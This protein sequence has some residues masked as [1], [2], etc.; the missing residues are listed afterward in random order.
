MLKPPNLLHISLILLCFMS[1]SLCVQVFG[2][3]NR[4]TPSSSQSKT[5]IAMTKR[6][7][8]L[9]VDAKLNGD[10]R[11]FILDGSSDKTLLNSK[12]IHEKRIATRRIKNVSVVPTNSCISENN[13]I[14]FYGIRL[15]SSRIETMDMSYIEKVTGVKIYGIVGYDL[16]KFYDLTFDYK[17]Q[18]ITLFKSIKHEEPFSPIPQKRIQWMLPFITL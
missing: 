15:N 9:I 8:Y 16:I 17:E 4:N 11:K 13:S 12:Y 1:E 3:K 5:T 18:T 6:G 14:E 10:T 2:E 7:T